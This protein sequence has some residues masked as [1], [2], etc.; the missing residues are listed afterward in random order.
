MET[1]I[2]GNYITDSKHITNEVLSY[3]SKL[4]LRILNLVNCSEITD[5]GLFHVTNHHFLKHLDLNGCKQ[6]TSEGLSHLTNL[7]LSCLD[8]SYCN[9]SIVGGIYKHLKNNPPR[10]LRAYGL[11]GEDRRAAGNAFLWLRNTPE[12]NKTKMVFQN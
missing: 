5:D 7:N 3:L 2:L 10:T 1:L 8:I 12:F 11:Y 9:K 4:P 6:V